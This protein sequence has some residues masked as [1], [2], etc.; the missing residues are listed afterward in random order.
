M[1]PVAKNRKMRGKKSQ[2]AME[3]IHTYGWV[4]LMA[5]VVGGVL[6]YYN[7]SNI[8]RIIPTECT[9]LS[10]V[11]C[12]DAVVEEY[13]DNETNVSG[14]LLTL[15]LTNGLGFAVSNISVNV[16]GAC[17]STA[18]TSDGNPYGNPAVLLESQQSTFVFECQNLTGTTFSEVMSLTYVNVETGQRHVK[19][20]RL[21]YSP[22]G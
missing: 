10:G 2:V 5:L 21:D 8:R 6:L 22:T 15:S 20:G 4:V 18:N 9:F 17:N 14:S 12:L 7:L 19:V 1:R 13:Y 3:L 11:S 16:T